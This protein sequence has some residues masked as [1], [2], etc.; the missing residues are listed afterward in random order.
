MTQ[1]PDTQAIKLRCIEVI[2]GFHHREALREDDI[3]EWVSHV[4]GTH[5]EAAIWHAVRASGFGGSDTGILARNFRGHRADHRCSAHDIVESK[6]LRSV[7]D[8]DNG[9]LS[10]GHDN[11]DVHA[12]RYYAKY[13]A[14]RDVDA[15][16]TLS[17]S[18]G[19]R[20]WMR[21]SP[22][23]VVKIP[24]KYQNPALG[25]AFARRLLID[26]K[27]P[28]V[29][30]EDDSVAFQYSCQL[31]QGAMICAKA[32]IHLDGLMLSQYDW[33]GWCLKDDNIPYDPEIARL[34]LEAGDFYF[35]FVMRG[36]LPQYVMTPRFEREQE[37]IDAFGKKAQLF[38]QMAATGE[39]FTKASEVVG[40]ELKDSL[41]DLRL[42]GKKMQLG[43]LAVSAASIV[44][45]EKINELLSKEEIALLRKKNAKPDYDTDAMAERLRALGGDPEAF[46]I[47]KIDAD[48]AYPVLIEKGYDP[49]QFMGEQIRFKVAEHLKVEAKELVKMSFPPEQKADIEVAQENQVSDDQIQAD[50]SA[51]TDVREADSTERQA[52]RTAMA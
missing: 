42:V 11:E 47:D 8:E 6:L 7:P 50:S 22:D 38:A 15:F 31:H 30:D 40:K 26:Y 48:K 36:E 9:D 39:A 52:Q 5:G 43:D 41:K 49:E 45:H 21:Y 4:V 46:R 18:Q 28:R 20:V 27:A 3:R 19:L 2:D 25:G 37:F 16:N 10:R 14:E 33:A 35:D 44:E 34:I 13:S 29:V 32:G 51:D 17:K 1:T 23:D 24:S 12:R